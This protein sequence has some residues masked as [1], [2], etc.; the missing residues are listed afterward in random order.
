MKDNK[1]IKPFH[2]M[3]GLGFL[4]G[5]L[6]ALQVVFTRIF[7]I[8]IWYHFAYLVIG[9]AL[10]GYGA[11]GAYLTIFNRVLTLEKLPK[12]VFI[13]GLVVVIDL[14]I[15]LQIQIDPLGGRDALSDAVF[16]LGLYFIAVFS[17]FFLGG[18]V[19]VFIFSAWAQ[20]ASRLYFADLLGASISTLAVT[21]LIRS[22]GGVNAVL[23]I[24]II[25]WFV[26][27]LFSSAMSNSWGNNI[28]VAVVICSGFL[29][30]TM[31][32]QQPQLP[33]PPSKELWMVMNSAGI[34]KPEYSVWNPVARVDVLP[35]VGF[36]DSYQW[37]I[38]GGLGT[39]AL[40][41]QKLYQH[42]IR[43]VTLDGTSITAIHEFNGDLSEYG[44]LHQ[45]I[46]NAP[47]LLTMERPSVL[48]IGVGGGL[49]ILLARTHQAKHIT[50]VELNG[51]VV[52]LL[53]GPYAEF[54]GNLYY[55]PH[56]EIV[57]AEGRS[58]LSREEMKYD[59][60]QGIGVDNFA[61]LSGG[62]YV[63][64]ESYLYTTESMELMISRLSDKGI[65]S[66]TRFLNDPPRETLRLSGLAAEALRH[67]GISNPYEHIAIIS[68]ENMDSGTLL[69]SK[70]P[71]SLEKVRMLRTWAVENHFIILQ[72]PYIN[73]G[74]I[75]ASYLRSEDPRMFESNYPFQISPVTDENPYFYNYFKWG[76][77]TLKGGGSGDLNTRLP[78]GN[79]V[80]LALLGFS[81]AAA[82]VFIVFP[83]MK[84]RRQSLRI[85]NASSK[86]GYFSMLGLGYIFVEIVFIQRFTLFVGYPTRAITT[87][88]FAM[89]FFSSLGSLA[90]KSLC[91]DLL[92]H[93]RFLL[94]LCGLI[95]IYI[96]GLKVIVALLLGLPDFA[97]IIVTVLLIAPVAFLMGMPFP[98]GMERISSQRTELLPWV[99]GVNGVFSVVGTTL[100]TFISMQANF[101]VSLVCANL[102]Y[103][104]AFI[105]SPSFW[106]DE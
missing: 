97:R 35:P 77:I 93:R 106:K 39:E 3:L 62:A 7:S 71:M 54:S 28:V 65:F 75:Y 104:C 96:F 14:F 16:G 1:S 53:K 98:I 18:L 81:T 38:F 44:F 33:I 40:R 4:S 30:Y 34:D 74:T 90:S 102:F 61:A 58:F 73:T 11:A 49:D 87:T 12:L 46:V 99:W 68:N 91:P 83:L 70:S 64:S 42:Q 89:L 37:I 50:A 67:L 5:S 60:I 27:V 63:L 23:V 31:N 25:I 59:L 57:V 41:N 85:P 103:L 2:L 66:W 19:V 76:N 21:W 56:T 43:F 9:I 51:D 10:L 26:S 101:T 80:L 55:D 86:L 17:V 29:L 100:V 105:L 92:N 82:T 88:I 15:I 95:L 47:Y 36:N 72:D 69:V 13:L 84:Y 94:M 24:V 6:I 45:A 48:L 8:T 22:F 79:L 78:V 20:H 32:A 52:D